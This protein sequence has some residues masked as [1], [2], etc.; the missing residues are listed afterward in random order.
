MNQ[1][2]LTLIINSVGPVIGKYITDQVRR[3]LPK[4]S[5]WKVRLLA[6]AIATGSTRARAS[7]IPRIAGP[8]RRR[9]HGAV[10]VRDADAKLC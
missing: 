8:D 9:L 10:S 4:L 5:T 7:E 1:E 6:M 2:L 3:F